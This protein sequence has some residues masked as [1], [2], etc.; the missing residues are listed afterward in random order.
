[1]C[2]MGDSRG[3]EDGRNRRSRVPGWC[4]PTPLGPARRSLARQVKVRRRRDDTQRKVSTLEKNR[5]ETGSA[6]PLS[7]RQIRPQTLKGQTGRRR[8]HCFYYIPPSD[9]SPSNPSDPRAA[10][11]DLPDPLFIRVAR[12][13]GAPPRARQQGRRL[14][15]G[16]GGPSHFPPDP[17]SPINSMHVRINTLIRRRY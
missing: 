10:P 8:Q 17:T 3:E 5:K 16:A 7:S 9:S 15:R 11:P 14:S 13:S 1:M 12:S 2:E 4:D 6:P